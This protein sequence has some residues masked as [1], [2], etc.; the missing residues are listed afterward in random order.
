M[1][2]QK[3]EFSWVTASIF[4]PIVAVIDFNKTIT[5]VQNCLG[6]T[7]WVGGQCTLDYLEESW[8]SNFAMELGDPARRKRKTNFAH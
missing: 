2:M 6:P 1:H 5:S 8:A 7:L 3:N 4:D